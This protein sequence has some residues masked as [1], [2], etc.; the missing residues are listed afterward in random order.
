MM[1]FYD[2]DHGG[3]LGYNEFM[4]FCLPCDNPEV[5]AEAC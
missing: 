5:R 1:N 4:K 3:S 2:L